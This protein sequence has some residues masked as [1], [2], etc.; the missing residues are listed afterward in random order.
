M[1]SQPQLQGRRG[2][3]VDSLAG[4]KEVEEQ[5]NRGTGVSKSGGAEGERRGRG[6]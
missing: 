6:G 1:E 2:R 5:D 3:R 4:R